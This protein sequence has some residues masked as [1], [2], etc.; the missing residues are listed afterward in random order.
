MA[1]S[2]NVVVSANDYVRKENSL[3]VG[4]QYL[5]LL[6]VS[7]GSDQASPGSS[8]ALSQPEVQGNS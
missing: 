2:T 5:P 3:G 4:V 7:K 6:L 8:A 1:V